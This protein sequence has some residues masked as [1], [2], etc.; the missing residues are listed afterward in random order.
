MLV[1]PI[2]KGSLE[3]SLKTVTLMLLKSVKEEEDALCALSGIGKRISW[4]QK[5][6]WPPRLSVFV[7]SAVEDKRTTQYGSC[8]PIF[9]RFGRFFYTETISDTARKVLPLIGLM[10][11]CTAFMT[12]TT[13]VPAFLAVAVDG[14]IMTSDAAI[15]IGRTTK[16]REGEDARQTASR[17]DRS[18]CWSW[19]VLLSR[20]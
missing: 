16:A 20:G 5:G 12:T 8:F 15:V 10:G 2:N 18:S 9:C 1:S 13:S 7:R 3:S 14:R 19:L 6:A 11:D 17:I 4:S